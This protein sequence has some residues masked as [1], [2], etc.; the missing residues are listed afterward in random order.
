MSSEKEKLSLALVGCLI[1]TSTWLFPGD[2]MRVEE[3]ISWS[4]LLLLGVPFLANWRAPR[5]EFLSALHS[6]R[7]VFSNPIQRAYA[8]ALICLLGSLA[9]SVLNPSHE[10]SYIPGSNVPVLSQLEYLEWMPASALAPESRT[11]VLS[12]GMLLAVT[13]PCTFFLFERRQTIRILLWLV[14]ANIVV[15][16]ICGLFVKLTG[17]TKILGKFEPADARYFFSTFTYKNH[18]GAYCLIALGAMGALAS[19]DLQTRTDRWARSR[20]S[21]LP[22]LVLA[23]V[24]VGITVPLSGSRSCTI[25]YGLFLI[26]FLGKL[27]SRMMTTPKGFG[28]GTNVLLSGATALTVGIGVLALSL[29]LHT[30]TREEMQRTTARQFE[31][32]KQGKIE[33]R[34]YISRDTLKMY[35]EKPVWGWGLGTYRFIINDPDR[36]LGDEH[37]YS[38]VYAH[39]DWLHYMAE[40]GIIGFGLLVALL[41]SPFILYKAQGLLNPVSSWLWGTV[42]LLWSYSFVEFPCRTPA[43]STLLTVIIALG[44]KYGILEKRWRTG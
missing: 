30:E 4:S 24:L 21:V 11:K 13:G 40:I 33:T 1:L 31:N 5:E 25:L 12:L 39:N 19:H 18:G 29:F 43:V 15:L 22:I 35:R 41:I 7:N 9:I 3:W 26:F 44:T 23:S 6:S 32:M 34:F 17:N 10:P 14:V 16:A 37:E 38:Y 36:F 28:K 20:R 42:F 2:P 8:L 27:L